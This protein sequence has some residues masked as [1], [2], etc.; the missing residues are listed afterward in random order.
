MP[1]IH[2][3]AQ[4]S[5]EQLLKAVEQMPSE[6]LNVFVTQVLAIR[7]RRDAPAIPPG[8]SELLERINRGVPSELQKRYGELAAKRDAGSLA[9]DEYHEL[10]QLSDEMERLNAKRVEALAELARL[11]QTSLPEL[12]HALGIEAPSHA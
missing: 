9:A 1:L 11:R 10:L 2:V 3:N 7:A 6:E 5:P 8:E 12:M 4:V